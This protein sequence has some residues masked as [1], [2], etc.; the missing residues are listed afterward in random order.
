MFPIETERTILREYQSSD[1]DVL[2]ELVQEPDIYRYQAWGPNDRQATRDFIAH[3]I[4]CQTNEPRYFFEVIVLS[5]ETEEV[6]GTI[7]IRMKDPV[8]KT[9][10]IG[11]WIRKDQWGKGYGTEIAK[12]IIQFGFEELGFHRIWA[13]AD[14][15]NTGSQKVLLKAGMKHEGT[16]RDEKIIRGEYRSSC[17][18][19]I[20]Q[21]DYL[22]SNS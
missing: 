15:E 22:K 17:Y 8:S 2:H 1:F 4:D 18:F 3:T 5:K 21:E 9:G 13:M 14:L 16:M 19:A 10:D 7:G 12:R 11:Y 6:L 20:L